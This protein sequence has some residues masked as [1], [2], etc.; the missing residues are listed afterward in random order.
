VFGLDIQALHPLHRRG[1]FI[2]PTQRLFALVA[3]AFDHLLRRAREKIGIAEL[4]VDAGDV[5]FGIAEFLGQP[6]I[7]KFGRTSE[8]C[9]QSPE[10]GAAWN[11]TAGMRPA[12]LFASGAPGA[13]IRRPPLGVAQ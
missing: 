8:R 11:R 4:G 2:A 5:S 9:L 6:H 3:F 13:W 10:G 12:V 7:C 1:K